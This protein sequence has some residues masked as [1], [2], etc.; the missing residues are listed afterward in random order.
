MWTL[1]S[2]FI[3][4]PEVWC[5]ILPKKCTDTAKGSQMCSAS[6][7]VLGA[8][9]NAVLIETC[10]DQLLLSGVERASLTPQMTT[11]H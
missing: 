1:K 10:R 2:R 11:G 8:R 3:L 7:H 9:A 4:R 6:Q 5:L